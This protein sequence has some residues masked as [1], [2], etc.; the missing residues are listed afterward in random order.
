MAE[1]HE[2]AVR[3]FLTEHPEFIPDFRYLP[4]DSGGEPELV[5]ST[6]GMIAFADWTIRTGRT[7]DMKKAK[8]FREAMRQ[9]FGR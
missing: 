2:L 8:Q 9:R 3:E 5:M 4:L 7:K 6:D 1:M